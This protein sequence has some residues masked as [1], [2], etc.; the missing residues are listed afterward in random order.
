MAVLIRFTQ[1]GTQQ[2]TSD[3]SGIVRL[4]CPPV[5]R[6]AVTAQSYRDDSVLLGDCQNARHIT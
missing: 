3:W 5:N 1:G 6:N 2:G 4:H